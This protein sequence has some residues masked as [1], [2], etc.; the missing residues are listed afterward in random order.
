MT[1]SNKKVNPY[2]IKEIAPHIA[3]ILL[4]WGGVFHLIDG[5]LLHYGLALPSSILKNSTFDPY[6]F[7][8]AAITT[9]AVLGF[10]EIVLGIGIYRKNKKSMVI[11]VLLVFILVVK[12]VFFR[13]LPLVILVE[14][15]F[16]F[17]F[18][19][20]LAYHEKD[21]SNSIRKLKQLV[22]WLSVILSLCFGIFG[23]YMLRHQYTNL[24]TII[25]AI[26]Y[27]IS[28]YSTVGYGDITPI[29]D[30]TKIFTSVMIIIGIGSFMTTLTFVFAPMVENKLKGIFNIMEKITNIKDHVIICGYTKLSKA[31]IANLNK[32]NIPYIVID[33]SAERAGELKE[34][35]ANF[36]IGS[37]SMKDVLHKAN[38]ENAKAVMCVYENDA[39]NIITIMAVKDILSQIKRGKEIKITTRVENDYNIEKYNLIGVDKIVS[40]FVLVADSMLDGVI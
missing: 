24:N 1:R 39:E 17:M 13:S 7:N 34:I 33:I 32:N 10:I 23:S 16:L 37:P 8:K 25:D 36:I 3:G 28:T 35:N 26:Y 38:I 22:A 5:V 11:A 2:S 40:P 9:E 14:V 4:I 30:E 21:N 20:A 29:T 12:C 18:I 6:F 15:F 27:T 19:L 31:I